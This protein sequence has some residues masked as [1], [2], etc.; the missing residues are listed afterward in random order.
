MSAL[1]LR[2]HR[3]LALL[4]AVPLLVVI[5][6]G[7]L[8]SFEPSLVVGS[9]APGTLTPAKVEALLAKHDP[10][11]QARGIAFRS[12]DGTLTIG[13]GRGT[14]GKVVDVGTGE[15]RAGPSTTAS[16]LTTS[17]QLHERLLLDAEWLV[18]ASSFVMLALALLGVLLGWPR[19]ANTLPGWHKGTAWVLLPL[20]VLSP[21]TGI[22]MA[23]R[24][25][26]APAPQAPR[27]SEGPAM[28]LVD[29]VRVVGGRHD[30]SRLVWLRPARGQVLARIVDGGEYRVFAV[31]PDGLTPAPRNWPRLL[32]EGNY[33]GH[34]SAW[35]NV[36]TSAAMLLLLVTGVW[37]WTRRRVRRLRT[38]PALAA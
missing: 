24:I 8:L 1:L 4:F 11:G 31:S 7:L 18:I 34:V 9:I 23:Y 17:R 27:G 37:I 14:P 3:W 32:H 10:G 30:L 2:L 6:T 20:L 33:A 5:A 19:F 28:K 29:A 16:V 35:I 22:F 36:V 15:L 21:L 13:G 12:Y 26:F 25:T 38:R